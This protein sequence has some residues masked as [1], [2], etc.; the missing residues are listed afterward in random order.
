MLVSYMPVKQSCPLCLASDSQ[1]FSRDRR[2]DYWQCSE[3]QL[4]FVP[5]DQRLTIAQEK[6]EYDLHQNTPDDEGYRQFLSRLVT[7]LQARLEGGETGLD[8]GCG[9][10]PALSVMM[11]EAGWPM[12]VYDPFYAPN[13]DCLARSYDFITATEVVEHIHNPAHWLAHLWSMILPGGSLGIMT[14]Q[15]IDQAAFA[16]WH[17][18]ND[19]TH[20]CFFSRETFFYLASQWGARL[21]FVGDDVIFFKKAQADEQADPCKAITVETTSL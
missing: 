6:A 13:E 7:P 3:C 11:A 12:D 8:F 17:Y 20:V 10:G 15:V 21:E 9:P 1:P 14:K 16:N 19:L 4:V 5:S 2:R 18:K